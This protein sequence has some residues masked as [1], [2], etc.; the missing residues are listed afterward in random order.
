MTSQM[1]VYAALARALAESGTQALFGL[2]GDGNLA[3]VDEL[4]NHHGIRYIA[5]N[6]ED[7]AVAAADGYSRVSGDVGVAT[8]THGP[9]LT[10]AV[11]A[12]HEAARAG[13]SLIVLCGDTD[14]RDPAHNQDIDQRSTVAPTGAGFVDL[15]HPTTIADDLEHAVRMARL[16]HRPVVLNLPVHLQVEE[17]AYEM[18]M[19]RTQSTGAL[20]P[21]PAVLDEALGIVASARRPVL[22]AGRGAIGAEAKR[23]MLRLAGLLEAPL[24]TTL[25]ASGLFSGEPYDLGVCGTV[26]SSVAASVLTQ[27]D[28][29]IGFGAGLNRY[30]T[31]YGSLLE[32]K[33]VVQVDV[34]HRA[35]GRWY[36][37]EAGVVGDAATVAAMM[38]DALDSHGVRPSGLATDD[39]A[40]QLA[41]YDP[42]DDYQDVSTEERIDPRTLMIW[43]DRT[44]PK[45]RVVVCDVGGFMEIPL[46]YLS[47]ADPRAHVLPAAFGSVG[48][49]MATAVGAGITGPPRP[50]LVVM[51]DG[52]WMMGGVNGF[53]TAVR[54]GLD[55]VAVVLNDGGYGIERRALEARGSDASM[56]SMAWPDPSRVALALGGDAVE[57]RCLDDLEHARRSIAERARPLLLDARIPP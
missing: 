57:I 28:C 31:S 21:D 54:Q 7:S 29:L 32:D 22:L 4:V 37:V 15:R 14:P 46:R 38:A 12:L 40:Q 48:L 53:D 16:D 27:A 6:R 45:D 26:S 55:V 36:P 11:T 33:A 52:G 49:A 44:L 34:D 41:R 30:T 51:G 50:V 56:A 20:R 47:V 13:T 19:L 43:L 5:V 9:G 35:I 2:L 10:N 25:K 17:V 39:L 3:L 18:P 1:P 8:V 42:A 23:S 24:A